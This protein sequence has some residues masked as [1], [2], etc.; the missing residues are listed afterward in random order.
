MLA[1]LDHYEE[2]TSVIIADLP[3]LPGGTPYSRTGNLVAI[4]CCVAVVGSLAT[5]LASGRKVK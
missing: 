5:A 4:L 1:H 2:D 3:I